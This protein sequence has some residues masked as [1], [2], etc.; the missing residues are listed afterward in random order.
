[1]NFKYI[2]IKVQ[3]IFTFNLVFSKVASIFFYHNKASRNSIE[4]CSSS[5]L[6]E[7]NQAS[8]KT[9]REIS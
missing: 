8:L 9:V 3:E 2:Y 5:I 4:C 1:M 6:S 7:K